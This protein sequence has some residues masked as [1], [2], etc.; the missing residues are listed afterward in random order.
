MNVAAL[1]VAAG[2]GTRMGRDLPKQYLGVA[3]RPILR[4]T[5]E[6]FLAHPGISSVSVVIHPE[7]RALYDAATDGVT[8]TRLTAP[9]HGADS[10][11]GSVRNGLESLGSA[12]THVLIH[13]AARAFCPAP[14]I[15]RVIDALGDRDGAFAALPV[16]DALWRAD[17]GLATDAVA[18]DQLW[19]AQTPQGFKLSAIRAAHRACTDPG[20]ADDVAVA[21]GHGL[22]VAIVEGDED[23]FKITTPADLIRAEQLAS[24][25]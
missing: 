8:A 24:R 16:V 9:V 5:I 19:R 11:A 15:D 18:R 12:V 7:D 14:V 20:A 22:S 2:R 4:H 17:A 13:D 10:R 3:G 1:V 23:N 6:R 21:R 25:I